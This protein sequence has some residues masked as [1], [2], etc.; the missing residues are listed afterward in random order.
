MWLLWGNLASIKIKMGRAGIL[1]PGSGLLTDSMYCLNYYSK[2]VKEISPL[3]GREA[4]WAES[5]SP[6]MSRS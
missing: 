5:R 6:K 3:K 4:W 2:L 1:A